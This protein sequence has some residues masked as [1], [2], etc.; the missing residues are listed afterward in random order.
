MDHLSVAFGREILKIVPGRVS[1]E[2]DARLSFDTEGTIAKAR[3]LIGLYEKAGDRPQADP[4]Q[5]RQHLGRHPGRR[6][7]GEGRNPLQ[8]DAPVQ[9]RPGGCLR[10]GQSDADL[11]VRRPDLRL[12][13]EGERGMRHP[14]RPDPGVASVTRIYNYYKKYDYKTQVMGASFRKVEQITHLAGCDLLT[15]SPDL[16]DKLAKDRRRNHPQADA[17]GGQGVRRREDPPRREDV[18]LDAQRRRHGHREAERRHPQV[19]RRRPQARALR[20]VASRPRR[21]R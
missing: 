19:L 1:T 18:P 9:L 13:Q 5:D 14:G 15:I 20:P 17:R 4:D 7:A 6:E 10:R 12:V 21:H 16:L 3:K 11:A 8:P 2:V